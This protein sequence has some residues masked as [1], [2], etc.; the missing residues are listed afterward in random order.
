M[1]FD[2]IFTIMEKNTLNSIAN[3]STVNQQNS[4]V[5]NKNID[6]AVLKV[7]DLILEND[8]IYGLQYR[9]K[10]SKESGGS[11]KKVERGELERERRK[12]C[13]ECVYCEYV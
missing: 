10:K 5:Q 7:Y 4:D 6:E 1:K 3:I 12:I 2:I 11:D 13:I 8:I 9:V